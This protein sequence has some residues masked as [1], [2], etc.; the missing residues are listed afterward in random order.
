[1][2]RVATTRTEHD[3]WVDGFVTA[4]VAFRDGR[5]TTD[6]PSVWPS[7]HGAWIDRDP[8][9]WLPM[10]ELSHRVAEARAA[11]VNV[12]LPQ[13]APDVPER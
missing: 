8:A 12:E 7:T 2:T 1:V 9:F 3:A 11:G 5:L 10:D 13:G 6:V 4:F